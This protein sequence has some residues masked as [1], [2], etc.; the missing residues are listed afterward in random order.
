MAM[1]QLALQEDFDR[2]VDVLGIGPPL[3]PGP[4]PIEPDPAVV[5]GSSHLPNQGSEQGPSTT[6]I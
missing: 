5:G 2:G 6:L 3:A 4:R 1:E